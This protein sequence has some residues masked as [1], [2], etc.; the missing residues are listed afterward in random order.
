[1]SEKTH[2]PTAKKLRDAQQK[3]QVAK[4]KLFS[5]AAVTLCGLTAT[6]AFAGES[7]HRFLTWTSTLLEAHDNSLTS[8]QAALNQ[9]VRVL[10][11]SA[12]PGLIGAFA[13][14][15]LSA[16]AMSGLQFNP[17]LV[18]PKL[19]RIDFTEG[20]KKLFSVRQV[21][22]VH[23]GLAVAAVIGWM[24]WNAV[25]TNAALAFSALHREGAPAFEALLT[26]LRP[27]V[28]QAALVLV[29]LGLADWAA[30]PR[31]HLKDLM[32]SHEELKQE[33]KNADGDPHQK[34]K[35]KSLHK[36]LATG[37][38]ARGAY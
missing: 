27:V 25:Q 4:S 24:F 10:A 3:G 15:L 6:L 20:L 14:A 26:L 1:M 33:H 19:E 17:T 31:R 8:P 35:R 11:L 32:M 9:G 37:G 2:Q 34:A 38:S 18:S 16:G 36:Q 29:G 30:G 7:W 23:V 5:S 28:L 21:L 13:A 22:D 12:A